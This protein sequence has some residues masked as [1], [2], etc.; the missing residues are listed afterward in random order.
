MSLILFQ[1]KTAKYILLSYNDNW[2][3]QTL[4]NNSNLDLKHIIAATASAVKMDPVKANVISFHTCMS[5]KIGVVVR[6]LEEG[7]YTTIKT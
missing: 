5:S 3:L 7:E 1:S 4:Y 6:T 2:F